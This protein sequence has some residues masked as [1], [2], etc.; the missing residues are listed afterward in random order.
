[1]ATKLDDKNLSGVIASIPKKGFTAKFWQDHRSVFVQGSGVAKCLKALN[2][3]DV[4]PSGDPSDVPLSSLQ[5]VIDYYYKL[6]AALLKAKKKCT[7]AQ[8][9]T[10]KF[11]DAFIKAALKRADEAEKRL[12]NIA[13]DEAVK[14]K[15]RQETEK[16]YAKFKKQQEKEQDL[17]LDKLADLDKRARNVTK[18]CEDMDQD[19]KLATA[20]VNKLIKGLDTQRDGNG[21]IVPEIAKR[22]ESGLE[23]IQ[24]K[25]K[26]PLHGQNLKT[27]L[28][29]IFKEMTKQ[30]LT[31]DKL[32]YAK[33]QRKSA[34]ASLMEASDSLQDAKDSFKTYAEAHKKLA[35][36]L[37]ETA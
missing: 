28:P 18:A 1:M 35:F 13:K 30:L 26:L 2:D 23:S 20:D 34:R 29:K 31:Y 24:K 25:H 21:K 27:S 17:M 16:E 14:E 32:D 3:R 5:T 33:Q 11:C 19:I 37:K 8:S 10:K 12:K 7:G 22:F 9:H 36:A 4:P 6:E 15:Q